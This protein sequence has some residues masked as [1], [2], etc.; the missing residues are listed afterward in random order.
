MST[1]DMSSVIT[2]SYISFIFSVCHV[3]THNTMRIATFILT[4]AILAQNDEDEV[5][6]P[7]DDGRLEIRLSQG[8]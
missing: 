5:C 8:I 7:S 6:F 1:Y 3:I 4:L 2:L